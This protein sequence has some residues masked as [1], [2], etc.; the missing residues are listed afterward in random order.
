[1]GQSILILSL[2]GGLSADFVAEEDPCAVK[3]AVQEI[4]KT[5]PAAHNLYDEYKLRL[6]V[7]GT[8]LKIDFIN[9]EGRL[10][11]SQNVPY[12]SKACTPS[13]D[14]ITLVLDTFFTDFTNCGNEDDAKRELPI[15]SLTVADEVVQTTLVRAP[16]SI[17]ANN[18]SNPERITKRS[19][20]SL[21]LK[22]E[23][24]GSSKKYTHNIE[25]GLFGTGESH[26]NHLALH[27]GGK[28][29]IKYS[30]PWFNLIG[31]VGAISPVRKSI[32]GT[33]TK[34]EENLRSTAIYALVGTG[35]CFYGKK[36]DLC[37]LGFAGREYFRGEFSSE[38]SGMRRDELLS[39]WL[40]EG[41]VEYGYGVLS[42]LNA[43][44]GANIGFRPGKLAFLGEEGMSQLDLSGWTWSAYTGFSFSLVRL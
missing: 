30:N 25:L 17:G 3:A 14:R 18:G 6:A 9:K 38:S 27:F 39:Q 34:P 33:G 32:K 28:L 5:R 35:K 21:S 23:I 2:L 22:S 1:M 36:Q 13:V 12:D 10:L 16:K 19:E 42:R 44:I 11:A 4:I 29:K 43:H 24:E 20:T 15:K 7:L 40:F 26:I 41:G 31:S 37:L 8:Q